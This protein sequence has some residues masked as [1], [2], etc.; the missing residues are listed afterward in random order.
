MNSGKVNE[1]GRHFVPQD[2][3]R[4]VG[5]DGGEGRIVYKDLDE[6]NKEATIKFETPDE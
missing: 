4:E 5:L 1:R 3:R 2:V 6:D